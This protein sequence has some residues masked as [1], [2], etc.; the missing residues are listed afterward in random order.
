M[1]QIRF[2]FRKNVYLFTIGHNS[3]WKSSQMALMS[4]I[5]EDWDNG[6]VSYAWYL[7]D[8]DWKR[9][10]NKRRDNRLYK[11]TK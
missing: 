4:L 5:R 8:T 7:W 10:Y 2:T 6:E 3:P 11:Q 9:R 1:L